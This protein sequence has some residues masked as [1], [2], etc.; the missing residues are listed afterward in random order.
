MS[1]MKNLHPIMILGAFI[2]LLVNLYGGETNTQIKAL[3]CIILADT[4]AALAAPL[5]HPPSI[6]THTPLIINTTTT[7]NNNTPLCPC[8]SRL[9]QWPVFL[10]VLP[11][12]RRLG[13]LPA[14]RERVSSLLRRQVAAAPLVRLLF[15]MMCAARVCAF[16]EGETNGPPR[17]LALKTAHHLRYVNRQ[18]APH[19]NPSVE[20]DRHRERH[21]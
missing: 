20:T 17:P 12:S 6:N 3:F 13:F 5:S 16:Q 19:T 15:M 7:N 18:T 2:Q 1:I 4:L 21:R 10:R 11:R 9:A 14:R 8:R